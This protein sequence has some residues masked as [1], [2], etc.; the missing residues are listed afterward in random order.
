MITAVRLENRP[1]AEVIAAYGVSKAWLY[2]LL[3]RYD[4]E[5]EAALEPRSRR[6]RSSP[7][8]TPRAVQH[9][10]GAVEAAITQPL[11]DQFVDD[12]VVDERTGPSDP[13]TIPMVFM[14]I[15]QNGRTI[16]GTFTQLRLHHSDLS[17]RMSIL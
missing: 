1:V 17:L 8:A 4:A 13:P 9:E 10:A 6:L 5:G 16:A 11:G 15:P 2:K 12:P 7:T 3:A 14:S